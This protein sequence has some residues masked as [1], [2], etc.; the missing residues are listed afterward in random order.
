[1]NKTY[2]NLIMWS[3]YA[4]LF[5][6]TIV[7]QSVFFGDVR[8]FGAK[9]SLIPIA[10]VCISMQVNHEQAAVFSLIAALFWHLSGADGGTM[11][12]ITLTV[13]GILSG[14]LCD[15]L[16]ARRLFLAVLLSIGA[17][18]IHEGSVFL[19]KCYLEQASLSR[20]IT[21]PVAA[22]LAIPCCP[23]LYLLGKLLRKAG[24]A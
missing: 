13:I 23:L 21:V 4:V 14:Y 10:I 5:M 20:W 24:A 8:F 1:M 19:L 18:V 16:Y 11:G 12:I 17:V 7:V 6:M 22:A 9:V 2:R 3:L 15:A